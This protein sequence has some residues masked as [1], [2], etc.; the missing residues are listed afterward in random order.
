LI[1]WINLSQRSKQPT[2]SW[3]QRY[4]RSTA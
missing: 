1:W 2:W 4:K 3:G